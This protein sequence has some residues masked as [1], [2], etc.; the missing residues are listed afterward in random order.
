[1]P[2]NQIHIYLPQDLKDRLAAKAQ[3][4]YSSVSQYVRE[5]IRKDVEK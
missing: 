5:L 1:M 4:Q 3:A 2:E